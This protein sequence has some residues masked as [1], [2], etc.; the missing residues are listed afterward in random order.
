[1]YCYRQIQMNLTSHGGLP[2]DKFLVEV[3][4]A[5]PALSEKNSGQVI[6]PG[7]SGQE[8]KILPQQRLLHQ[9][10]AL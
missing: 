7:F 1:M 5:V 4:K 8:L 3:E 10:Y 9:G 2:G 6:S